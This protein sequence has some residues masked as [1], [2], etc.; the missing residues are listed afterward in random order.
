MVEKAYIQSNSPHK[1]RS[2]MKPDSIKKN[3]QLLDTAKELRKNMTK[4]EKHLW[5]DF[6]RHY[7]IK[8]YKH[9]DY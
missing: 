2:V 9:T 6:L 7:P 3:N 4:Q 5:Y 8:I 1:I